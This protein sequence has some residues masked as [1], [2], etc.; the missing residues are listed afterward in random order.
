MGLA[1][2]AWAP[3]ARHPHT[4]CPLG[5]VGMEASQGA[6]L[7]RLSAFSGSCGLRLAHMPQCQGAGG[8]TAWKVALGTQ[9]SQQAERNEKWGTT[10]P[11]RGLWLQ[12]RGG[13][14][15]EYATPLRTLQPPLVTLPKPAFAASPPSASG[16]VS[17]TL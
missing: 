4:F 7:G 17:R 6:A 11:G 16:A 14:R 1:W 5:G 13:G 3:L 9:V 15:A 8:R 10:P 12:P 2:V